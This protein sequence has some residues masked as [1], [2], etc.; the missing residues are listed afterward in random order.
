MDTIEIGASG[1]RIHWAT[2]LKHTWKRLKSALDELPTEPETEKPLKSRPIQ[3]SKAARASC[4]Y[5]QAAMK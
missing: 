5:A 1:A 4:L 3:V 2:G